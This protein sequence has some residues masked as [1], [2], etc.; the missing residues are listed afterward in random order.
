MDPFE[1]PFEKES[2]LC[3]HPFAGAMLVAWGVDH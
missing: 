3:N 2:N 1:E